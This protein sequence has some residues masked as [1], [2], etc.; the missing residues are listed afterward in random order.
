M[1]GLAAAGLLGGCA[2]VSPHEN[3]KSLSPPA[4]HHYFS[5]DGGS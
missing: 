3:P 1:G 4:P 2:T 5:V